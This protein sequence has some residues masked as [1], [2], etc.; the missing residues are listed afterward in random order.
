MTG[1]R[2]II[3]ICFILML[4]FFFWGCSNLNNT[5]NN[6][7]QENTLEA[8]TEEQVFPDRA[9]QIVVPYAPGGG[10]DSVA[11]AL[12]DSA[13]KYFDNAI[14][15]VNKTG[16]GG[17][18]GMA[19]GMNAR[20][21]GYTVTMITSELVTLSNFGLISFTYNDLIPILQVNEDA[22]ALVVKADAPWNTV[23]DFI[24]HARYNPD[25][26]SVGN[27]GEGSIW[28][29]AAAYI[30]KVTGT[31]LNHVFYNGAAPAVVDLLGGYIDAVIAS[32]PEVLTHV[33][34]GELKVLGTMSAERVEM[35]PKIPTFKEQG[36]NIIVNTWRGLGVPKETPREIV[37]ILEDGFK[38]AAQDPNYLDIINQ[39]EL[40]YKVA[41]S[42]EF[43]ENMKSHHEN[44]KALIEKWDIR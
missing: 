32:P 26:I 38:K 42:R 25:K 7:L 43:L 27:S 3:G 34:S 24:K 36:Y 40:G 17:A 19:E 35:L 22:G 8:L 30:E 33:K 11:R 2:K 1:N 14:V 29:F 9:I 10:T 39:L 13:K 41:G 15:V 28:Y 37:E 31:K 12:A 4:I 16:E 5:S 20:P 18:I 21:D 23:E 6:S 44:L